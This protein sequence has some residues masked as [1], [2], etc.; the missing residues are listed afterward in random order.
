VLSLY[1][2]AANAPNDAER[3]AL[4]KAGSQEPLGS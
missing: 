3:D 4:V 2:D 1:A